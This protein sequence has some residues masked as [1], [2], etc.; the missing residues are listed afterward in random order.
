MIRQED[1]VV[2]KI[3]DQ[4]SGMEPDVLANIFKPYYTTKKRGMGLGLSIVKRIIDDH[5]GVLKIDGSLGRGT[6]ITIL[7]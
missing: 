7:F 4:G 5:N 6:E 2:I 1:S 3:K